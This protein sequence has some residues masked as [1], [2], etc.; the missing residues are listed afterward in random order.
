V[1]KRPAGVRRHVRAAWFD[2]R[3]AGVLGRLVLVLAVAL[4]AVTA[5]PAAAAPEPAFQTCRDR[6]FAPDATR[7]WRHP[8]GGRVTTRLGRARHA[9]AD[10]V[11]PDAAAVVLRAKFAYGK[12]SKD[13]EGE[14][15]RIWIDDCAGWHLVGDAITD[16]DGRIAVALPAGVIDAP[17]VYEVR[18][19][20]HGDRSTTTARV[21]LLP[22]GTRI[23]VADLDGTLTTGDRELVHELVDGHRAR[24]APAAAALTTAHAE[25]GH[26]VVY[27]T[28]RPYL[29]A[30]RT[31]AWLDDLGF[32]AGPVIIADRIRQAV[33]SKGGVGAFK[34]ARIAALIGKGYVIDGAYGNA[35]TDI[36]AYLGGG[37]AAGATWIIG[38]HGGKR[39]THAV[40]GGW[41][42]R[43]AD[44]AA[45]AAVAQPFAR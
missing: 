5:A 33:P 2:L 1:A 25:R 15:V 38:E 23:V 44:V 20:V 28:G 21:W 22:A 40:T 30:R 45:M 42:A 18:Y 24:P 16:D 37:V 35:S 19:Q 32:A 26:V 13:L 41:T 31:R 14:S 12:L 34:R 27:L 4:I 29:L 9:A 36:S 3:V 43:A 10:A 17:G 39:G 8:L 11:E 6:A 7:G